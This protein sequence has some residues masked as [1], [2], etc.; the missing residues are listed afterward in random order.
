MK[1]TET[2]T[3][4]VSLLGG[5]EFNAEDIDWAMDLPAG[6]RLLDWL[7][8]Q[9]ELE[10]AA[11]DDAT[12]DSLRA[13]LQAI[14]LENDEVQMLRHATV[15]K[16][17][18]RPA[19]NEIEPKI[20]AGYIPPWRLRAKE[21]Y[22]VAEAVRLEAE[23]ESL[24]ARLQQA[25]IASQSLTHAIKSLASAIEKTE[26]DIRGA[27]D[28][29][30]E[31]SLN[32][33]AA[34]RGSLNSSIG[35]I[36]GCP[37]DDFARDESSRL[38]SI[39]SARSAITARFQSLMH[40]LDTAERQ[41]P[42]PSELHAECT[43]LDALRSKACADPIEIARLCAVL[44]D[45]ETGKDALAAVLT[46]PEHQPPVTVDVVAE[47][48]AAWACDQAAIL[49]ARGV[50][51]DEGITA[52]SDS[53][54]PPLTALHANLSAQ[55]AHTREAQAFLGALCAEMGDIGEDVR[56][57]REAPSPQLNAEVELECKDTDLQMGLT[58][59]LNQLKDLRARDAPPLGLLS[60][61]DILAELRGVYARDEV[62][63]RQEEEWVGNLLPTLRN[64]ETA[65]APLLD[66]AY[67]YSA[68][69]SSPPFC[70]PTDVRAVREDAKSKSEGLGDAV[71]KLQ[72]DVKGLTSERA[73]RRMEQFV[74]KWVK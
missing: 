49:D 5:P 60:Q 33:D 14:S 11:A 73:K 50:I 34:L 13:A 61:E 4:I 44:E 66:A 17:V 12:S 70:V 36:N 47:L 1:T 7:V 57:A 28:G 65:H 20:P 18:S 26:N 55:T 67:A 37:L 45:L 46:E 48:G 63:R 51:L 52:F 31:L 64:L 62:S 40:A 56:A 16:V 6:Q 29:L 38:S 74:L 69:N 8:S 3:A 54:L 27:E 19:T 59:L 25:K 10:V 9:V 2:A 41:L 23:T 35:L 72:E 71:A 58:G 15:K 30:S 53:L 21:Q 42:T 22:T 68:L 39:S 43:R 32:A 24:K